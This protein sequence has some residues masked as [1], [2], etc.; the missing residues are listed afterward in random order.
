[1]GG[2]STQNAAQRRLH[3]FERMRPTVARS[4]RVEVQKRDVLLRSNGLKH[5]FGIGSVARDDATLGEPCL[6]HGGVM[7]GHG[8]DVEGRGLGSRRFEFHSEDGSMQA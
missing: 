7:S 2:P 8:S 6:L 4:C 1:M 5:A 3:L